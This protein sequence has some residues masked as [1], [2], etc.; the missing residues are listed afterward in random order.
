MSIVNIANKV[1]GLAA[2]IWFDNWWQIIVNRIL[3]PRTGCIVYRKADTE[4]IIDHL[5]GD[6][7]GVREC[8]AGNMYRP[9][10]EYVVQD[11]GG[12]I[13]TL[14]DIGANGGGF[15]LLCQNMGL[16][17]TD[18][19]CVEMN[20]R[21]FGRLS[22]NLFQNLYGISIQ[23]IQ[24][25]LAN[26]PGIYEIPL[27][28]GSTGENLAA[29]ERIPSERNDH[30]RCLTLSNIIDHTDKIIIDL[31]KIDV[32]GVEHEVF[33]GDS[34]DSIKKVRYLIMEIHDVSGYSSE[35]LL[36]RLK[37]LGFDDVSPANRAEPAVFVFKNRKLI[38]I[39][40]N[41]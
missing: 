22:F 19:T 4:M 9:L 20:P 33:S 40:G 26:E 1:A 5:G 21:V 32:E 25:A 12:D 8:L 15:T 10:I 13:K 35:T 30:I 11:T 17:L 41:L 38:D 37:E 36:V 28:R 7:N 31:L 23:A 24:G 6:A 27:G 3:F 29:R 16:P 14:I 18:V 39:I 2:M 34:C